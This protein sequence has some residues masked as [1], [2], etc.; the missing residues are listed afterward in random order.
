MFNHDN[1]CI[2]DDYCIGAAPASETP[3]ASAVLVSATEEKLVA[4]KSAV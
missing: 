4:M 1:Y 2:D 3:Q